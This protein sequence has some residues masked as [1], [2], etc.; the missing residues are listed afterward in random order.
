MFLSRNCQR[1]I[2]TREGSARELAKRAFEDSLPN[3]SLHVPN[4]NQKIVC[5][6]SQHFSVRGKAQA[7]HRVIRSDCEPQVLLPTR[8]IPDYHDTVTSTRSEQIA[9]R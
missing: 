1:R 7:G 8:G 2:I 5:A 9:I 4:V 6:A 3:P